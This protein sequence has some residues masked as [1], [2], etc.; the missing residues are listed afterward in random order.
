MLALSLVFLALLQLSYSDHCK[1]TAKP[2]SYD[3]TNTAK[4]PV[5]S[6]SKLGAF[7]TVGPSVPDVN[8]FVEQGRARI[9][10][11]FVSCAVPSPYENTLKQWK[12]AS[13]EITLIGRI[14][15]P[16]GPPQIYSGSQQHWA[17]VW[18][19][20][21]KPHVLAH[22]SIDYWEGYNEPSTKLADIA[23]LAEWEIQRMTLL[24]AIGKRSGIG[25]YGPGGVPIANATVSAFLPAIKEGIKH[26]SIML[27]HEYSAPWLDYLYNYTSH[28]GWLTGRYRKLYRNFL[29]PL[30]LKIPLAITEM[31]VDGGIAQNPTK[32]KGGWKH[33]K[34]YWAAHGCSNSSLAY[35]GQLKWY[36]SLLREDDYVIGVTI[37][38]LGL[39][40][41]W[42]AWEI[43]GKV[44][45][46]MIPYMRALPPPGPALD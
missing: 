23:W 43:S 20:W 35:F 44:V 10:K 45:D 37:F 34:K 28:D 7:T 40:S 30:N 14:D 33:F 24:T 32:I 8:K 29:I 6:Y 17:E 2:H 38:D 42:L 1:W 46:Y 11:T 4:A 31:G 13:P 19:A 18:M 9:M 36:D 5:T 22:P 25:N 27:E 41:D 3:P 12:A 16:N 39:D 15:C 26:K 21:A